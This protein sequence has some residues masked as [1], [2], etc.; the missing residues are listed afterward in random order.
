MVF[1]DED[2]YVAED[3]EASGALDAH[4]RARLVI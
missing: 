2:W 1:V 4:E 3:R